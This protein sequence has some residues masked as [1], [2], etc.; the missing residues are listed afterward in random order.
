MSMSHIDDQG[1][2][3]CD[4]P[5]HSEKKCPKCQDSGV[6]IKFNEHDPAVVKFDYPSPSVTKCP[7]CQKP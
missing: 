6:V 5:K 1:V 3:D 2:G 4:L 7:D